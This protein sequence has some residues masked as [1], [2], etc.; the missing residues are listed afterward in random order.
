MLRVERPGRAAPLNDALDAAAG[1][2]VGGARRRRHRHHRLGRRL[3]GARGGRARHGPP[4]RRPAPGRRTG[5]RLR[6]GGRGR[7]S[8]RGRSGPPR[9]AGRVQPGRPPL[10]Q[11]VALHDGRVP[12]WG[13]RRPRSAVRRVPRHQRGLGLPGPGRLPGRGEQHLRPDERVPPLDGA[14]RGLATS[15]ATRCGATR[16]PPSWPA[17]TPRHC[18]SRRARPGR[19]GRCGRRS[20]TRPP[21]KFRFAA[22]NEQAAAD[23]VTV[24]EA[25]VALRARI[26]ELEERL[27][28]RKQRRASPRERATTHGCRGRPS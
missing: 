7:R 26:A 13:L 14:A 17:W 20:S 22:L 21:E 25:V 2:Y 11:R 10:G 19:S 23:L 1:R 3:R 9:V 5:G 4:R 28:R 24:N 18:C 12:A 15:T 6:R 16:G 27:E 8:A